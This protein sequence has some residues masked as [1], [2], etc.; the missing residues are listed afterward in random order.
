MPTAWEP[1]PGNRKAIGVCGTGGR[2]SVDG[3][4]ATAAVAAG[5]WE[6]AVSMADPFTADFVPTDTLS[7]T[8]ASAFLRRRSALAIFRSAASFARRMSSVSS[9]SSNHVYFSSSLL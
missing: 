5:F 7:A 8:A 1:W 3:A 2:D 6:L 9:G 4:A